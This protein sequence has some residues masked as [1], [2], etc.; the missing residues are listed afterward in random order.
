MAYVVINK[1]NIAN[2]AR[3]LLNLTGRAGVEMTS[4][5]KVVCG[6]P[7]IVS[8]IIE[9]GVREIGESRLENI[10]RIRKSG[11]S[12]TFLLLRLPSPQ[13]YRKVVESV[14]YPPERVEIPEGSQGTLRRVGPPLEVHLHGGY[15]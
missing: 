6:D 7:E 2:N 15:R 5:T 13:L 9:T 3:Y 8:K 1:L 4:V 12:P 11:L 10:D 14:D